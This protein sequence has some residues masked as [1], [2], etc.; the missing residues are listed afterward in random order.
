MQNKSTIFLL[1]ANSLNISIPSLEFM[2]SLLKTYLLDFMKHSIQHVYLD[3]TSSKDLEIFRLTRLFGLLTR[4][5]G[6]PE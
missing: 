6:A 4:L 3:C 2:Q 1:L 5:L